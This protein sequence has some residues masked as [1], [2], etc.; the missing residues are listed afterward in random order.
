L[1]YGGAPEMNYGFNTF[2]GGSAGNWQASI[3]RSN[4]TI[5]LSLDLKTSGVFC[6]HQLRVVAPTLLFRR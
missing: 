2:G 3:V 4:L 6:K 1:I 5:Y